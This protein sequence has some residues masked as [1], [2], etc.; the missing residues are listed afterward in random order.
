MIAGERRGDSDLSGAMTA[1]DLASD[2]TRAL[3]LTPVSRE[4]LER[5]DHLVAVLLQWRLRVN[6]IA[7]S[8]YGN[9]WTRHVADSLQLVTLA[10][11]AKVWVDLGSGAG[12]PG[13]VIACA[14]ADTPEARVHLIE[15]NAKKAAFLREAVQVTGAP[16]VVHAVRI[17]DI[18]ENIPAP[19][20]IVT[21]RALAPLSAL[22]AAAYP[23]LKK[24]AAGVF[25]KGQNVGA[26]LTEATKCWSIEASLVPSRTEAKAKIV[27]VTGIRPLAQPIGVA[28]PKSR[29]RGE[30]Q[31]R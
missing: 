10:P 8:T 24:G 1:T 11:N 18:V 7:A 2:R 16:A 3:A 29:N 5:L 6:L 31:A 27:V 21:A 28:A 30:K 15:S 14:L 26:E 23:L 19:V 20:D 22:L 17:E 12:F 9:L 4:T 25:P 13:L